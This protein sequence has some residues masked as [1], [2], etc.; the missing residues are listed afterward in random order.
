MSEHTF[1]HPDVGAWTTIDEVS[2]AMRA[3]YRIGTI[4]IAPDPNPGPYRK[5]NGMEWYTDTPVPTLDE[6]RG[7]KTA[8]IDAAAHALL[9]TGAPVSVGLHIA[10]DE[11]SRADLTAMAATATAA[12]S[13]AVPWPESYARGWITIENV[14]I[15]LATPADG[16]ALAALV[17]NYY[18]TIVQHRRDL[19]DAALAAETAEALN[20][21]DETAGWPE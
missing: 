17:G 1:Y 3:E 16:L 9:A 12:A 11:G 21:I 5:Y 4:E 15:P 19:K 10:L 20:A 14:R 6:V 18:A 7:A 2:D 13:G 8:A